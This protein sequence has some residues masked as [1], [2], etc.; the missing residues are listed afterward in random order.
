[1]KPKINIL[2]AAGGTGGHL[3]PALA[4]AAQLNSKKYRPYLFSD[5]RC[6]KYLQQ[7][8]PYEVK[9][10]KTYRLSKNPFKLLAFLWGTYKQLRIIIQH[11]KNVETE[12]I[13]SFGGYSAFAANLAALITRTKLI[14]HEQNMIAGRQNKFFAKHA[15]YIACSFPETQ[16]FAAYPAKIKLTGLPVRQ[17]FKQ[18]KKTTSKKFKILVLGGSQGAAFL[19]RMLQDIIT[20]L[21]KNLRKNIVV[22]QQVRE[23]QLE[24]LN[25]FYQEQNIKAELQS[26]FHNVAEHFAA[27]DLIISRAGASSVAEILAVG[28]TA[29]LVPFPY[30]KDNHQLYNA[31]YLTDNNAAYLVEEHNF[32]AREVANLIADLMRDPELLQE[33]CKAQEQLKKQHKFSELAKLLELG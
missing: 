7:E 22:T 21:N 19:S 5:D 10:F 32:D 11:L 26:Y 24:Q 12:Y 6:A 33:I 17:E 13:V 25:K 15:K 27:A 9:I 29:I 20:N 31:R 1:M 14:I 30:A 28:K 18:L 16:G 2:L 8:L 3:S 23:S 4:L